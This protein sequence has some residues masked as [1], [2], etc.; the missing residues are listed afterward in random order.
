MGEI[1]PF[2]DRG[3]IS[4]LYNPLFVNDP[5]V[6]TLAIMRTKVEDGKFVPYHPSLINLIMSNTSCEPMFTT[7]AAKTSIF[8]LAKYMAN[9]LSV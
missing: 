2:P 5:S 6:L 7:Q 8:Y 9:L 1:D 4:Y 3:N